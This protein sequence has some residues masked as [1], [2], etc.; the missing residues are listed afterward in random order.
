M[1][2]YLPDNIDD[3][4][5]GQLKNYSEEP[6]ENVWN[7][8][9]RRLPGN[10]NNK[11]LNPAVHVLSTAAILL[12]CLGIP[13]FIKDNFMKNDTTLES[14]SISSAPND[15]Q[16]ITAAKLS[17]TTSIYAHFTVNI[18]KKQNTMLLST[19]Q[20]DHLAENYSVTVLPNNMD[21][22][23]TNEHSD[24]LAPGNFSFHDLTQRNK[25]NEHA[26]A[27]INIKLHNK[28]LF[29]LTPFFSIDH[30]TG[31]FIEQYEFDNLDKND[32]AGRE[33]PDMSF[34]AGLLAGYQLNRRFSLV[35]G[36][37]YSSSNLSVAGAAVKAL[38]ND[39]GEYVFKM[40]TSYGFAEITKSGIEPSAGDSLL[41]SSA[42]I[43][44]TYISIPLMINY[45]LPGKKIKFSFHGGVA[46]NKLTSEKVEAEYKVQDNKEAETINKIEGIR[47][48]FFTL[49]TGI[50]VKYLINHATDISIGPEL[51]YGINSI[52]KGTPVK[53][54]PVNYG[55]SL[56]M[57]FKL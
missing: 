17:H 52:N 57:N 44:F 36:I 25:E 39:N 15:T 45:D 42:A 51:R 29:S 11:R 8:I 38:Q 34:T 2:K 9:D 1:N 21:D 50:D 46:V 35:S 27:S 3:F 14:K 28:H 10:K 43:N 37:S 55:L 54:Y 33:K 5:S 30:I 13:F 53:T 4:F 16:K 24:N 6:G 22:D 49:N 12:F 20:H 26:P 41:V 23:P 7:E 47:K 48:T 18:Q 19:L 31:R 56:K 32:L 40:A